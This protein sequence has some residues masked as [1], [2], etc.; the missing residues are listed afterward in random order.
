MRTGRAIAWLRGV[1]VAV[2]VA[3]V[4]GMVVLWPRGDAPDLGIRPT[5]YVDATVRSIDTRDCD[6][7]EVPGAL[8]GCRVLGVELTSGDRSG[9]TTTVTVLDTQLE[10]PVV[11]DGDRIVLLDTR[12]PDDATRYTFV[13]FQRGPPL[14]A[15]TVLFVVV[16][17]AF[18]RLRGLRALFGLLASALVLVLFIVPALLRDAPALPV[19]LV[20]TV[21]IAF[22]A[23]YLAHGLNVPTTVALAGTLA[24]LVVIALLSLSVSAATHLTGLGDEAAQTLRITA[25][26]L[27]LRGLLIAGM[28]VG[29]LGVL[30]DVTVTQVSA[31]QALLRARPDIPRRHLYSEAIHIGRDHIASTVN[32]LILAY[33]GAALPLL[34]FFAEGV[35]PTSRIITGELVAVE[36]VRMMVG[37]IGLV[38]SVPITTALAALVITPDHALAGHSHGHAEAPVGEPDDDP[39][40]R[41]DEWDR[42]APRDDLDL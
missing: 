32:T 34:L 14:V 10:V 37:S 6:S 21:V 8:S 36:I 5:T 16:V 19:A 29:A 18:G 23:L 25:S 41:G 42:F 15:L 4:V 26:E 20:G 1:V 30:D 24:S 13:D 27:D 31:V 9:T 12:S 33:A 3:A 7:V 11:H 17:I 28:V 35:A 39:A 40:D 38:L 2:G 22:L